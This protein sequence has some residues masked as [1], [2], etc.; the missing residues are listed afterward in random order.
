MS[1]PCPPFVRLICFACQVMSTLDQ[2]TLTHCKSV[3][4][5]KSPGR[6]F[7]RGREMVNKARIFGVTLA[8]GASLL[9]QGCGYGRIYNVVRPTEVTVDQALADVG[10]GLGRMKQGI[11]A[12]GIRS[13]GL[14]VDEVEVTFNVAASA[15]R[16]GKLTLDASV[17]IVVPSAKSDGGLSAKGEFENKDAASRSNQI[18]I[19]FKNWYTASLNSNGASKKTPPDV[20]LEQLP[21]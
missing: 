11:N 8:V 3:M 6:D 18:K 2:L 9:A 12:G 4:Q 13:A 21:E 1:L 17:P 20:L 7:V 5:N 10:V 14:L 19:K 16:S 15:D